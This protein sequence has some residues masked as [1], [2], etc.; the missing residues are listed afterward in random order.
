VSRDRLPTAQ[1]VR[2]AAL[3][4]AKEWAWDPFGEI[5]EKRIGKQEFY[6]LMIIAAIRK[7]RAIEK[8]HQKR[9]KKVN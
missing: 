1:R 3:R 8:A 6:R 9:N 2:N 7:G 4:D 5:L